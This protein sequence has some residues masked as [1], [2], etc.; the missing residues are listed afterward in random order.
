MANIINITEDT[1]LDALVGLRVRVARRVQG[2]E[3]IHIG[4]FLSLWHDDR[5]PYAAGILDEEPRGDYRGTVG[6]FHLPYGST[7][8]VLADEGSA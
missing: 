7:L 5:R 2:N 3:S 6:G 1:D 8:T 4:R